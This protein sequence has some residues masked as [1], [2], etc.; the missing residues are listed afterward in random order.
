ML[1]YVKKYRIFCLLA[2]LFMVGEVAM[3]LLQPDLMATIVD[4]GVLKNDISLIVSVGIKMIL[5]VLLGGTAGVMC[6]VFANIAAQG[7]GNDLRKDL[8]TGIMGLSFQQTDKISTGSLVTRLTNDVTQVQNM[9]SLLIRGF[10]RNVVMFAGGVFMLYRQSPKFALVAACGI[11][12]VTV[13][14]TFFLKK[15]SPLFRTVQEKLDGV[16]N[17]MQE[18]VAGARVVKAFV[19]E[20]RELER[21]DKANDDLVRHNLRVQTIL[22]FMG[23]CMNIILN[24]CVVG[25][26][27]LGGAEVKA[28]GDMTPG[29]IMAAITYLAQILMGFGFMANIFQSFTRA[30]A[31]ADRINEVLRDPPALADG[32]STQKETER[33]SVE[34]RNVSFSYPGASGDVLRN[35]DLTVKQGETLGIVGATG[36]GK[37]TLV[38]LIP[39]FY[40]ATEG[41]ILVDGRNVRDYPLE[42]LRDKISVVMQT[43]ELY[44]R[45]IAENIAWGNENASPEEIKAA[46]E[47]AQADDFICASPFGYHTQVTESG[48]SLSGGQKQRISIARALLKKHEIL[49]FDDATSALD[50]KTEAA[51]YAALGKREADVTKII[52]AQ[53]V[54]SVKDADRILVLDN[55]EVSA[56]D[57]HENLIR[58]SDIYREIY[59]SQLKE[60]GAA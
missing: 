20:D 54:A 25:V 11:P 3:D 12:F 50:L 27:L 59:Q 1:K 52:I 38:G 47:A 17:V 36:C 19:M 26:I 60:G 37:T 40:D 5:F 46:A 31:S 51:L 21:F 42:D 58:T 9:V 34:F 43:S 2:P 10:V 55:G 45:S 28:G 29:R 53:R 30:K 57:T 33:G 7:F 48:H 41:E 35:V 32:E 49:I 14:V 8:F 15:A 44:S 23:P 4:D 56:L 16:N 39:R 6:G 22:A 24:L 18:D 13:T